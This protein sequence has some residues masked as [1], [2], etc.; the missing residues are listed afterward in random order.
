[1]GIESQSTVTVCAKVFP[2]YEKAD[3]YLLD[4]GIEKDSE[5]YDKALKELITKQVKEVNRS[6]PGYKAIKSVEIRKTEFEKTTT[7]KIKRQLVK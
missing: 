2:D 1:M 5:N 3:K 7:K 4:K 6:L